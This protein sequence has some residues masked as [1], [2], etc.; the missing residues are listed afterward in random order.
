[1][2]IHTFIHTLYIIVYVM[3]IHACIHTYIRDECTYNYYTSVL[4]YIHY[5][6]R[7][8]KGYITSEDTKQGSYIQYIY[9]S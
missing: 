4:V 5:I 2:C 9:H 6:A 1:M 8:C 3:C 7:A